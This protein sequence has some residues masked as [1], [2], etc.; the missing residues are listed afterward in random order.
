MEDAVDRAAS[1]AAWHLHEVRE[2][3]VRTEADIEA[4]SADLGW[5]GKPTGAAPRG[6]VWRRLVS[7]VE[8]PADPTEHAG[9]AEEG[10]RRHAARGGKGRARSGIGG[11]GVSVVPAAERNRAGRAGWRTA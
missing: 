4:A 1:D 3:G 2:H 9:A 11:R 8:Q 5:R 6:A 7:G 10:H